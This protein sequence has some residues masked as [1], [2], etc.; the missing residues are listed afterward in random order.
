MATENINL[1]IVQ[2]IVHWL[3]TPTNSYLGSGYGI[4]LYSELQKP[5]SDFS[6]DRI[7]AKM[8]EDI[9]ILSKVGRGYV[10]IYAADNGIDDVRIFINVG[11]SQVSSGLSGGYLGGIDI[12]LY[13]LVQTGARGVISRRNAYMERMREVAK[14]EEQAAVKPL[15]DDITTD[16]LFLYQPFERLILARQSGSIPEFN[17]A[18]L[19]NLFRQAGASF[20]EKWG[21]GDDIRPETLSFSFA[22]KPNTKYSFIYLAIPTDIELHPLNKNTIELVK[23]KYMLLTSKARRENGSYEGLTL[24]PVKVRTAG[25][26]A[27]DGVYTYDLHYNPTATNRTGDVYDWRLKLRN[28]MGN[29]L[30]YYN[31]WDIPN[32]YSEIQGGQGVAVTNEDELIE[33]FK[34][35]ALYN[36]GKIYPD[37]VVS[38]EFAAWVKKNAESKAKYENGAFPFPVSV[39]SYPSDGK[40]V[41]AADY[42]EKTV[43]RFDAPIDGALTSFFANK[44]KTFPYPISVGGIKFAQMHGGVLE[45]KDS[46]ARKIEFDLAK[47]IIGRLRIIE[48][49]LK[50]HEFEFLAY[51]YTDNLNVLKTPLGATD[52]MFWNLGYFTEPPLFNV[53][54]TQNKLEQSDLNITRYAVDMRDSPYGILYSRPFDDWY[55]QTS[56]SHELTLSFAFFAN[57]DTL[58]LVNSVRDWTV[59]SLYAANTEKDPTKEA[60]EKP[61]FKIVLSGVNGRSG[62]SLVN[63]NGNAVCVLPHTEMNL[64]EG[65]NYVSLRVKGNKAQFTVNNGKDLHSINATHDSINSLTTDANSPNVFMMI[66]GDKDI[67]MGKQIGLPCMIDELRVYDRWLPDDDLMPIIGKK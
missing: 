59:I 26:V 48:G 2:Q 36:L 45:N 53:K 66:R 25:G 63:G 37:N 7:I 67:L 15:V 58:K 34:K 55:A 51:R 47:R 13:A 57:K 28:S 42:T 21:D 16:G 1:F 22:A 5:L 24:Y 18:R 49:E 11:G 10:N 12:D 43:M 9:P 40:N 64:R 31:G 29:G 19:D 44:Q 38:P 3:N 8:Y 50:P 62:L 39:I 33:A 14:K 6:S 65:W 17:E 46:K 54:E 20:S 23:A 52:F 30:S 27:V 41:G 4:D 32:E 35:I 61:V 60:N 56:K